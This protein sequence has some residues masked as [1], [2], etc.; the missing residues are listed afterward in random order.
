MIRVATVASDAR[1]ED[2]KESFFFSAFCF[3]AAGALS[4]V[5]LRFAGGLAQFF[6]FVGCRSYGRFKMTRP[7]IFLKTTDSGG[8]ISAC[9]DGVGNFL[10]SLHDG[11]A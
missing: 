8:S 9:G 1:P 2:V 3:L 6:S 10:S 7:F 4:F 5:L 11:H